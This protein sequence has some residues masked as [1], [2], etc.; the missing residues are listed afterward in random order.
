[1]AD[2]DI[3]IATGDYDRVR[4]I[5]EGRVRIEGCTARYLTPPLEELFI[6]ALVAAEFDACEV[7]LSSYLIARSRG[8]TAYRAL[9]IFLSR[10]FRHSAFYIRTDRGI[11]TPEDLKGKT[12]GVPEYQMTAAL[13]ARGLLEDEYGVPPSA[14]DWRNGGLEQTGRVEKLKL[15]LPESIRLTPIGPEDTLSAMLAD[16]RLDALVTPRAPSCFARGAANV[17]RL[18]PDYRSA[19]RDYFRKTGLFPIMHV[20]AVRE[21]LLEAHPWL[22]SSLFFAFKEAKN[23]A[24]H[25]LEEMGVSMVTVPWLASEL[26][27]LR[28][29]MGEDFW[30][31]GIEKNRKALDAALRYS[32]SQGLSARKLPIEEAFVPDL[33]W[34][35]RV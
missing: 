13:W 7:S 28:A 15:D 9:P 3:S 12:V 33:D 5:K 1:M 25:A 24:V 4:A 30:P 29:L 2:L 32:W 22:A 6:R 14:I 26:A 18:F 34:A 11:R 21:A 17:A 10:V 31:Y 16:G 23:M 20:L 19:E 27:D 8:K 35:V